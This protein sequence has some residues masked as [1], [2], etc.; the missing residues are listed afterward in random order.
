MP[1]FHHLRHCRRTSYFFLDRH[2][3]RMARSTVL[4]S[5]S[6]R[7]SFEEPLQP[8]PVVQRVADCLGDWTA[9]AAMRC[10]V[11]VAMGAF[12]FARS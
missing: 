3:G 1:S 12:A 10:S 9:S 11:S 7:P 6:M 4:L 5:S 2:T 8:I